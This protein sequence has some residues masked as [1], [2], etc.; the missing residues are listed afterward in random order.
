MDVYLGV[1]EDG[2]DAER[3]EQLSLLLRDELLQLD[4][5]AVQPRG[6]APPPGAK[7]G[8]LGAVA[9]ALV[10][11]LKP[12]LESLSALVS[13]VRAWLARGGRRSIRLEI[14]GDVLDLSGPSAELQQRL[15][16][17]W[18]RQHAAG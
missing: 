15:A 14:D 17:E 1:G 11:S 9:G 8:T 6:V 5:E 10:V 4:A 12:T 2:A 16:E 18:I 3:L 7:G 13:I